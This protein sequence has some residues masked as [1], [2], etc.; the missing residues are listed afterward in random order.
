MSVSLNRAILEAFTATALQ[1]ALERS[2][3]ELLRRL[4]PL[5]AQFVAATVRPS[6]ELESLEEYLAREGDI[7]F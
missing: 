4:E 6:A 1:G 3:F 7:P 2:C 5:H